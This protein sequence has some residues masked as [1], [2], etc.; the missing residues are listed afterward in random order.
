MH[1]RTA[2]SQC[3]EELTFLQ[4]NAWLRFRLTQ[5]LVVVAIGTGKETEVTFKS[6]CLKSTLA[7]EQGK[8]KPEI[9]SDLTQTAADINPS[10]SF[11]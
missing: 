11:I 1:E 2:H 7:F 3:L 10:E 6:Y 4:K 5:L 8:P 9:E